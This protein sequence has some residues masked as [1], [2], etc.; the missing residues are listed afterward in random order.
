ML[1]LASSPSPSRTAIAGRGIHWPAASGSAIAPRFRHDANTIDVGKSHLVDHVAK[2]RWQVEEAE[3]LLLFW[4][5]G[6]LDL[7]LQWSF[8]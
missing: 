3:R 1:E 2:L 6:G 7:L 8:L 5:R 4:L